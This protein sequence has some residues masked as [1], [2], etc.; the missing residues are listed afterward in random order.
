M[1]HQFNAGSQPHS[2]IPF[3]GDAPREIAT[4][5]AQR[6]HVRRNRAGEVG[7]RVKRRAL[8][9]RIRVRR[10]SSPRADVIDLARH[11]LIM[12]E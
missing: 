1:R 2:G 4:E 9:T 11:L 10:A 5:P 3:I 6:L 12:C 8:A 7:I